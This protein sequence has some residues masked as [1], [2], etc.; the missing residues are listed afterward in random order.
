MSGDGTYTYSLFVNVSTT[1]SDERRIDA[2][3]S[4]KSCTA[5]LISCRRAKISESSDIK[6]GK[7]DVSVDVDVT[8]ITVTIA[9]ST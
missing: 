4:L 6:T 3:V 2:G 8:G 5:F 9:F 1:G 7:I